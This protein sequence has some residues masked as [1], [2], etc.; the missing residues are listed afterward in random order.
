LAAA[1]TLAGLLAGVGA[2]ADDLE[3][4]LLV[5]MR[6]AAIAWVASPKMNTRLPVR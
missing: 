4:Q 3:G 2:E 5:A 1:R 6:A